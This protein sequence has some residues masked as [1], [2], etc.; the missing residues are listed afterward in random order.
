MAGD[1]GARMDGGDRIDVSVLA[2]LDEIDAAA[3]DACAAPGDGRPE[4]PFTTHRFLRALETSGS[5]AADLDMR[6]KTWV[7]RE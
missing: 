1:G 2:G 7:L 5:E 6:V 4:D 3:W